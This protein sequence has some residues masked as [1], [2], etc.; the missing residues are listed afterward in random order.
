MSASPTRSSSFRAAALASSVFSLFSSTGA[1]MMFLSTV[2]LGNRLKCWNTM[3]MFSRTLLMSVRRSLM[4]IS[5]TMTVP[6]VMSSSRFRQRSKVLLPEPEGPMTQTTSPSWTFRSMPLRTW[7]VPKLF[8]SPVT[9]ILPILDLPFHPVGNLRQH[10]DDDEVHD[11]YRRPDVER[12][13]RAGDDDLARLGQLHESD[14]GQDRRILERDDHLVDEG[15]NH[16][17]H[18]LRNDDFDHRLAVGQAQRARRFHLAAVDGL[19][20]AADDLRHIRAGV[21]RERQDGRQEERHL[22]VERLRNAEI[23]EECQHDQRYAAEDVHEYR[24]DAAQPAIAAD[25]HEAEDQTQNEGEEERYDCVQQRF[26]ESLEQRRQRFG[27]ERPA[28]LVRRSY[29]VFFLDFFQLA[30]LLQV[31]KALVELFQQ[32]GVLAL[33]YRKTIGSPFGPLTDRFQA[34]VLLDAILEHGVIVEASGRVAPLDLVVH[35]GGV[36]ERHEREAVSGADGFR[37]R[38]SFRTGFDRYPL[39]LEILIAFDGVVVGLDRHDHPGCEVRSGKVELRLALV[40]DAHA[41]DDAVH[42]LR[43]Q[44]LYG[45]VEAERLDVDLEVL[46][47]RDR[48]DQIHVDAD[49]LAVGI[50]ELERSERDIRGDVIRF[51]GLLGRRSRLGVPGHSRRRKQ[52]NCHC[53]P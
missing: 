39:A 7:F 27:D 50:L 52:H 36:I 5:S 15:W 10:R 3:P 49:I 31:R 35:L 40:G 18:R 47:L 51:D 45:R 41:G 25:L 16:D 23:N 21:E 48:P 6:S 34:V 53:K 44:R 12:L 4:S 11:R 9:L 20:A 30:V 37:I 26:A 29:E 19:D 43:L 14:D 13:E 32:L 2:I 28:G 24:G 8:L 22:E 42:L 1:N 46:V 33:P 38:I 17:L